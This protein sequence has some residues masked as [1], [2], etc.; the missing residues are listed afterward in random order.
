ME[1]LPLETQTLYAQMME[2]LLALEAHRSIGLLT[3]C[4]TT[5]TVKGLLYYTRGRAT[6]GYLARLG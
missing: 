6:G 2:T 3:G 4:F 5:K 1:K